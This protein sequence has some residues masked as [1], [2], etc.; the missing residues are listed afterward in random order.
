MCF[1]H[2]L[3]LL[4]ESHVA[5]TLDADEYHVV[6]VFVGLS[7]ARS[8]AYLIMDCSPGSNRQYCTS[9]SASR[10]SRYDHCRGKSIQKTKTCG[11]YGVLLDVGWIHVLKCCKTVEGHKRLDPVPSEDLGDFLGVKVMEVRIG[12]TAA[13]EVGYDE[14][15]TGREDEEDETQG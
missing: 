1:D 11:M 8:V 12:M 14:I 4:W 13:T 5:D 9:T 6:G 7:W 3:N 15:N 2:T 10:G